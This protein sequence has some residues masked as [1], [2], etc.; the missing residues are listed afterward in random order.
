MYPNPFPFPPGPV[1]G[2]GMT[3]P[4][5]QVPVGGPAAGMAPS[6]EVQREVDKAFLTM[7]KQQ[8]MQGI[9]ALDAYRKLLEEQLAGIDSQLEKLSQAAREGKDGSADSQVSV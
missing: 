7:Q 1:P 4:L 5:P 6:A 9:Q 3:P 2:I 8:L